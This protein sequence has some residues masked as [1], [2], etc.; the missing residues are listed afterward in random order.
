VMPT[1]ATG[2]ITKTQWR[3]FLPIIVR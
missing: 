1:S 3:V 2:V